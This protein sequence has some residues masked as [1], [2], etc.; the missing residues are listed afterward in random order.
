M[1]MLKGESLQSLTLFR[2]MDDFCESTTNEYIHDRYFAD[3]T[4]HPCIYAFFVIGTGDDLSIVGYMMGCSA[5]L[6]DMFSGGEE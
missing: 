1:R 4:Q 2:A 3:P 5:V 6:Y